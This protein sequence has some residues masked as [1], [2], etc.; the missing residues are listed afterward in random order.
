MTTGRLIAGID[1]RNST[2]RGYAFDESA[3]A[4]HGFTRASAPTQA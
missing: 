1:G 2:S 4:L 3:E